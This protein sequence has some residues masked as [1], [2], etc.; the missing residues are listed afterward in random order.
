MSILLTLIYIGG[1]MG[2]FDSNGSLRGIFWPYFL[3]RRLGEWCAPDR[4]E[5]P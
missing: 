2:A 4:G 5:T 3:G 1:A